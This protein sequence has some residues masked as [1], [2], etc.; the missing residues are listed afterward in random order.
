M[1]GVDDLAVMS[2]DGGKVIADKLGADD[3]LHNG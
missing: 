2:K 3:V 1:T